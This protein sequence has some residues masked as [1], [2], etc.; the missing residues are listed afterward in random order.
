MKE[1]IQCVCAQ[2][3]DKGQV[4]QNLWNPKQVELQFLQETFFSHS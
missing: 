3:E 1:R 2:R 4:N